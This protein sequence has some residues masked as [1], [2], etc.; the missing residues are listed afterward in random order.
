MLTQERSVQRIEESDG[1]G[2]ATAAQPIAPYTF[3]DLLDR[4]AEK[5]GLDLAF[6]I[7][8][9]KAS[10]GTV[11][12]LFQQNNFQVINF[13]MTTSEFFETL[14]DERRLLDAYR[15]PAPRPHSHLLSGHFR[16]D[17]PIFRRIGAR[18]FIVTTLRDPIDRMLSNYNHTLR[19]PG[20]L[21]HEEVVSGRMPFIEH[22]A[23]VYA[24]IGPQYS[25][26]DDTGR[27]TFAPTGRA[28]PQECLNNLLY[29]VTFY[30]LTDRFNEFSLL[31][32]IEVI[33]L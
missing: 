12:L 26:F 23:K 16:L 32:G 33:F 27:G 21:W 2:E 3:Q 25:F 4:N 18:H 11:A 8:V 7:H 31:F 5:Q 24:A 15:A 20:N 10:G 13:D 9:P 1:H 29:K 30:G 17:H 14:S 22:A 28:T 6:H 19:V